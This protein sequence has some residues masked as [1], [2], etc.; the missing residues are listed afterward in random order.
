ME[1]RPALIRCTCMDRHEERV[2]KASLRERAE[3]VKS[4]DTTPF[5]NECVSVELI[6]LLLTGKVHTSWEGWS[7]GTLGLGFLAPVPRPIDA[8]LTRPKRPVWLLEG[9]SGFSVVVLK[10]CQDFGRD[11]AKFAVMDAPGSVAQLFH[12]N[13]WYGIQQATK[14]R[15]VTAGDPTASP[16][17]VKAT[18]KSP[19]KGPESISPGLVFT[20]EE[21]DEVEAHPD[22]Q[23]YYKDRFRYW[24]YRFGGD[25]VPFHRLSERD[26]FRVETKLGPRLQAILWT[27]WPRA[28]LDRF[29]P[30]EPVV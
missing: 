22:D 8:R 30:G 6:S 5:G 9:E 24:R 3:L 23:K 14:V 18:I 7:T 28:T 4:E 11:Q 27:R 26:R 21:L 29:Q 10:E 15:M 17:S 25:W 12:W 19:A 1:E 13:P 2:E 20:A 16:T